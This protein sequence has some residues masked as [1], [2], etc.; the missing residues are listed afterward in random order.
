LLVPFVTAA[1]PTR[2]R[3]DEARRQVFAITGSNRTERARIPSP[4]AATTERAERELHIL[5]RLR[6][7]QACR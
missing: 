4:D 2:S 5:R 1:P 3:S 7:S 6:A